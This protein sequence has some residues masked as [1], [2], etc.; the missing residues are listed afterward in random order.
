MNGPTATGVRRDT[1]SFAAAELG[2]LAGDSAASAWVLRALG[3][4]RPDAA[5]SR[6][7]QSTL[8]VRGCAV[9]DGDLLRPIGKSLVVAASLRAVSHVVT[10]A[11][12][13]PTAKG[14]THVLCSP[15]ST[16]LFTPRAAG[17]WDID[18]VAPDVGAAGATRLLLESA[19]SGGEEAA[20]AAELHTPAG[21]EAV[22]VI[23]GPS[24]V[25]RWH[26]TDGEERTGGIDGVRAAVADLLS[27]A[28][29]TSG[30]SPP[31]SAGPIDG[32]KTTLTERV[33]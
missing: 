6:H 11:A 31:L 19:L 23:C 9:L 15:R 22:V 26:R 12:Y 5:V 16:L 32:E 20:A 7:A 13:S 17:C 24:G 3:I 14:A 25:L 21:D 10:V 4:A 29:E 28:E 1:I 8:L 27:R 18:A 30:A 2:V 33:S